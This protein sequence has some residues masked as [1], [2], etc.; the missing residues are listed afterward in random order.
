M[1]DGNWSHRISYSYVSINKKVLV[2]AFKKA[3]ANT[4]CI[5]L[6]VNNICTKDF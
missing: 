3:K 1:F 5:Y 2:D 6:T 4:F